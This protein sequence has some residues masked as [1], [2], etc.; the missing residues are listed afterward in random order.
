[1]ALSSDE[2]KYGISVGDSTLARWVPQVIDL[3]IALEKTVQR[4][5]GAGDRDHDDEFHNAV[6]AYHDTCLELIKARGMSA[7]EKKKAEAEKKE[8]DVLYKSQQDAAIAGMNTEHKGPGKRAR[9]NARPASLA[10]DADPMPGFDLDDDEYDDDDD[11]ASYDGG[12]G[13]D[14]SPTGVHR[15]P[16]VNAGGALMPNG[17]AVHQAA[18]P[19]VRAPPQ[20]PSPKRRGFLELVVVLKTSA[21][22]EA[23]ASAKQVELDARCVRGGP[24]LRGRISNST[25]GAWWSKSRLKSG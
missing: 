2:H 7:V 6:K 19:R 11:D 18:P 21:D 24:P 3:V 22:A 12:R 5:S 4:D 8:M 1:L 16:V 20:P 9:A 13:G 10:G 17:A 25:L 23:A 15:A 14:D